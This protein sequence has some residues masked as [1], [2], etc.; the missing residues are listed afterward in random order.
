MWIDIFFSTEDAICLESG[1]DSACVIYV[2]V[3]SDGANQPVINVHPAK[4]I[5]VFYRDGVPVLRAAGTGQAVDVG[6][7][8]GVDD[9]G[10]DIG[11]GD[12]GTDVGVDDV[13]L[14]VDSFVGDTFIDF[15]C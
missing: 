12:V 9:V 1:A 14:G 7:D 15:Q 13:G 3:D 4:V 11:V 5:Y 2:L 10:T 6:T 8:V